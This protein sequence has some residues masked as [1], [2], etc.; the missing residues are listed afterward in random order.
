MNTERLEAFSDGVMAILITIMVLELD[1]PEAVTLDS[2]FAVVPVLLSYILSF[3]YL[4]IYWINHHHL[5]RATS[6]VN[7]SILWLNLLLLFCLSL[8]PFATSWMDEHHQSA[9]PVAF[10]GAILLLCASA[11]YF[12]QRKIVQTEEAGSVLKQSVTV[13]LKFM[14][15]FGL[16]FGGSIV[17]FVNT[18]PAIVFYIVSALL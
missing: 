16:C 15:S 8:I 5:L 12:L 3:V 10:Y 14:L 7:G 6:K 18:W 2:L 4:G 1:A 13:N 17:A 9:I 11:Y